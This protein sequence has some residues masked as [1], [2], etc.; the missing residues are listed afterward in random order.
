MLEDLIDL[1]E[2]LSERADF[3]D[4]GNAVGIILYDYQNP[5]ILGLDRSDFH[6]GLEHGLKYEEAN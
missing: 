1:L 4:I 2:S 6:R 5:D 3:S